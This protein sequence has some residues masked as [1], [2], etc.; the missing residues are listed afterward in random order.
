M[1]PHHAVLAFVALLLA[2]CSGSPQD[3]AGG[4]ATVEITDKEFSPTTRNVGEGAVVEWVNT[5]SNKHTVTGD[6]G[7]FDSGELA[8]G[9]KWTRTFDQAGDFAYHCKI[10]PGMTGIIKVGKS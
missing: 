6:G 8:A 10:H 9:A 1:R 5:G 2:G 4:K 7:S 3:P